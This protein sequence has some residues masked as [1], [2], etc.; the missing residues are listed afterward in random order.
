LVMVYGDTNS[1]LAGALAAAKLGISVAHVEAGL[2]SNNFS[3]PEEINRKVVDQVSKWLFCPTTVA[4]DNLR[5]EGF[6]SSTY[7]RIHNVGDVMYDAALFYANFNSKLKRKIEGPFALVTVHRA[8]NVDNVNRIRS[9]FN[10]LNAIGEDYKIVLPM[11]PRTLKQ[12]KKMDIDSRNIHIIEPVGYIEMLSLLKNANFV[13]TDSG[14][15]QKEAYFFKKPC[16]VLREETEWVEL[17][18]HGSTILAGASFE[19]ILSAVTRVQNTKFD[20]STSLYGDGNA[21]SKIVK[22]LAEGEMV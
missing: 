1:T 6:F 17:I 20:F 15:L 14:G 19:R 11:H 7:H 9:I 10:A 16:V 21:G 18:N 2:R 12:I 5:N 8:E 13:I 3:M 4:I 22:L